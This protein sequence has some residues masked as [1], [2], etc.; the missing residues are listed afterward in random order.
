M[1]ATV[2]R[3]PPSF[4]WWSLQTVGK[5]R[6]TE[7]LKQSHV[8][9][10]WGSQLRFGCLGL[11]FESFSQ[12]HCTKHAPDVVFVTA[13]PERNS[14]QAS[15][16]G[17]EVSVCVTTWVPCKCW[18]LWECV[19]HPGLPLSSGS[20]ET[21]PE[22]CRGVGNQPKQW[23][24]HRNKELVL[25]GSTSQV[26]LVIR[27]PS[28]LLGYLGEKLGQQNTYCFFCSKCQAWWRWIGHLFYSLRRSGKP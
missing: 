23:R 1:C 14:F 20:G 28:H 5:C 26:I 22:C 2:G 7:I 3:I 21:S 15:L 6:K 12:F 10:Q 8:K 13:V 18:C 4:W 27:H 24:G 17:T 11:I 25:L 9:T 16:K 19:C